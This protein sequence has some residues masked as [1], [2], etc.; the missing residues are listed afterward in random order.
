MPVGKAWFAHFLAGVVPSLPP[1]EEAFDEGNSL[2]GDP[3]DDG[4]H[5]GIYG[6]LNNVSRTIEKGHDPVADSRNGI[7]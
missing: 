4:T 7:L 6:D 5:G 2:L 1:T 3:I